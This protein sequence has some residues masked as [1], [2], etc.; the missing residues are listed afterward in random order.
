MSTRTE[1]STKY[2]LFEIRADSH[3]RIT[4]LRTV[5]L[6]YF[7]TGSKLPNFTISYGII[8]AWERKSLP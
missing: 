8:Y 5:V 3:P 6:D 2:I 4:V 1:E 7:T